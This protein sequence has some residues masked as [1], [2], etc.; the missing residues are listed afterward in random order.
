MHQMQIRRWNVVLFK[1]T[2]PLIESNINA[3]AEQEP[4]PNK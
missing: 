3:L 4:L 1:F 2:K